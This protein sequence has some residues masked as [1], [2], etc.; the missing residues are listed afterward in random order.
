MGLNAQLSDPRKHIYKMF[1]SK[2]VLLSDLS[3]A[4]RDF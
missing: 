1:I 4:D 3:G 2:K